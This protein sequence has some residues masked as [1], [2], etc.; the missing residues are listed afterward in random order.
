MINQK[1]TSSKKSK[2]LNPKFLIGSLDYADFPEFNLLNIPCKIDTGAQTSAIH[3]HHIRLIEIEGKEIIAFNLLDPSHSDYNEKE[4]RTS[5]F[6]ERKV[7][8]SS[9]YAEYRYVI[10]TDIILFGKVFKTEFT[11]ADREQMRY[12]VLIGRRLLK[13]SFIVDVAKKNLSYKDKNNRLKT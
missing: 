1:P 8:S 3:C 10:T 2:V 9:G 12:P 4:Y 5:D 13:D 11:L 6:K 7:R